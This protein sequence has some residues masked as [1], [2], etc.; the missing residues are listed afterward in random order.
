[1]MSQKEIGTEIEGV[2]WPAGCKLF[3]LLLELPFSGLG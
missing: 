1:M 3:G 2:F